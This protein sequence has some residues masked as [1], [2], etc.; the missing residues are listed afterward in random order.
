MKKNSNRIVD[1]DFDF[2]I[3]CNDK[4]FLIQKR[5]FGTFSHLP[6]A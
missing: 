3:S 1:F 6:V 5:I 4:A 2:D